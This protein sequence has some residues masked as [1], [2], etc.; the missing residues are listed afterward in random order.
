LVILL[1][2]VSILFAL[3]SI[4]PLLLSAAGWSAAINQCPNGNDCH[5]AR[6]AGI[7]GIVFALVLLG[8]AYLYWPKSQGQE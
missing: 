1:R 3:A 7:L 4:A 6:M 5:D 2:I 8:L